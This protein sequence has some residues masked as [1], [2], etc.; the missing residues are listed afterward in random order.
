MGRTMPCDGITGCAENALTSAEA[1]GERL[2]ESC[3]TDG[4]VGGV[5]LEIEAHCVAPAD[6]SRRPGWDELTTA[7]AG[8]PPLPGGSLVTVEPGG[9]VELS[10][11]PAAGRPRDRHD[12][13]L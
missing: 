5:G 12:G 8:L 1:A 6:P 13:R 7:I 4:P 9:A 10:G 2:V 11:P 3:L